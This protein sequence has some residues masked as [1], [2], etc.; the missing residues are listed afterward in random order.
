MAVLLWQRAE[1]VRFVLPAEAILGRSRACELRIEGASVSGRHALLRWTEEGWR[2]R[3]LGSRNGTWVDGRPVSAGE[4]V[5]LIAGQG[6]R[7]GEEEL[8]VVSDEA[9]RAMAVPQD[10]GPPVF[11]EDGLLSLPPDAEE[12]LVQL[13]QG[14]DGAW[15]LEQDGESGPAPEALELAGQRWRLHFPAGVTATLGLEAP[16]LERV[17]L[18]FRVSFD[19]EWAQLVLRTPTEE[20]ELPGRTHHY[21]LLTLARRRGEDQAEGLPEAARGWL[22]QDELSHMLRISSSQVNLQVFRARKQLADA[23]VLNA[24]SLVE[25]RGRSGQLR[26]GVARFTE[27]RV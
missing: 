7:L 9:P 18:H 16:T 6:L 5:D 20:I 24:A 12:A 15:L 10:G 17:G 11:A 22:H 13:F 14:A 27:E 25:R 1:P 3:D 26:L 21:L 19:E 2:L 8:R 23:G 4:D